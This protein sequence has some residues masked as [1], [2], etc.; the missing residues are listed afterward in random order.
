MGGLIV[1]LIAERQP[2]G[3]PLYHGAV[4]IGAALQVREPGAPQLT[5]RPQIPLLFL[6]NQSEL[7]GP[8]NYVA[9]A[10]PADSTLQPVLWRVSRDGHVNV[11]QRERLAA[12]RGVQAWLDRGRTALPTPAHG[13][14]FHDAT[15]V[16]QPGPSRVTVHA[17]RRGFDVRVLEVSAIYG[18]VL[19]DA[20]P[21]DFAAAG[22]APMTWF[23]LKAHGETFRVLH[24]RGFGS[25][26]RGEWVTFANADGLT[27]LARNQADAATTAKLRAGDRITLR[28]GAASAP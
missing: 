26:Q 21:G 7:D 28:Q 4:A 8:R 16:I 17:D 1:T 22:I 6:T 9:A 10:Q 11:N 3:L 24:G 13:A 27:W 25:V 18:N 15:I 5:S 14:P 2:A 23:E 19:L 20:Q 12:L